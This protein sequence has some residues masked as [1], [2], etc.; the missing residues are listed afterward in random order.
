MYSDSKVCAL[1]VEID[2]RIIVWRI[3][4]APA[5]VSPAIQWNRYG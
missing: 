2:W 4:V 5:H 3:I 1:L